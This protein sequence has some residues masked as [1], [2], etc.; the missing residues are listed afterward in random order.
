M[1]CSHYLTVAVSMAP[2]C[3]SLENL[4]YKQPRSPPHSTITIRHF[5]QNPIIRE[6]TKY[7]KYYNCLL[8]V[9]AVFSTARI[10]KYPYPCTKNS[11]KRANFHLGNFHSGRDQNE[12]AQHQWFFKKFKFYILQ[13][14]QYRAYVEHWPIENSLQ[15]KERNT[16]TQIVKKMRIYYIRFS[17]MGNG[18][19]GLFS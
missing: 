12:T 9:A 1:L 17:V 16:I 15:T 18:R 2:Q 8:S 13:D 5:T 3:L 10:I 6:R 7:F 19:I 11:L 4:Q 14:F